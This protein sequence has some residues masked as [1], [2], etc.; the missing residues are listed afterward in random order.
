VDRTERFDTDIDAEGWEEWERLLR[1]HLPP[2]ISL[3]NPDQVDAAVDAIYAA[4]NEACKATM[5]TVGSAPG[6]NSRWWN[7]ECKAAARA[8]RGG[9]W[10]DEEQ[11]AANKHLKTV[12]RN[13]KRRWA[14]EY[15]TT[16]NVWEV[17]AWRHGR[18][19]SHIP[20][21]LNQ[22]NS[23][24]FEHEEMASLLSAR[25][26]AEE[27]VPIPHRFHDDLE[28]RPARAFVPFD[29]EEVEVLLRM[30]ANKLAPGTSGIGWSLLKKGWGAVK[31]HLLII[32][33]ACFYLGHH[34][35]RWR[36]AKVV[37]IPKL[38]KPDYSLPKAH[39]PISLLETM[40]K[41]LEKA[42]AKRM[43]YDI[44]K[45]ELV[46][47]NQFGGRAHSSCL[48][49]GLALL[50]DVQEAHRRGL[51]CGILLFNVRG[52]F[53]NVNHGR[54]TAI[55]ENL[56]YPP[57]LVQWSEAFLKDRKVCL[58]FNN[59]I[60]DERGQ[61]IGVPQGSPLSPVFS[62][63]YTSSLLAMMKGWNNSSL[64]M[65]VDDGI[66]FAC[67]E[68]W[69]DV[70]RLLT[71]RYTVC[72]EWLRRSGLAIKPDKTELLFFQKPYER[73]ATQAPTRLILPDPAIQ[74]YYVVLP[75][76]GRLAVVSDVDDGGFALN[77][78]K[79]LR[80]SAVL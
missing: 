77:V 67:A 8:M 10:T 44:V 42:V 73:N 41:L 40:S 59:V 56:G 35:A 66:L 18:R 20:A 2:L 47:A 63:T 53:D 1:F 69:R 14:D 33:N 9:F 22:S 70:S 31:D 64:G 7:D 37:V 49:A 79:E 45:Y 39:R 46:Q 60:S 23:L 50:H 5:K 29:E 48:D 36:E 54:M 51:K 32:Y 72:E 24:V 74:S 13:A 12:I 68:D 58:S 62:I 25:F 19:S 30:M 71:A 6:F 27:A 4:F 28:P 3:H 55:L 26:F 61:P 21:L 15:I 11:R 43:Q 80:G 76:Y 75:C 16:A 38:D 78:D 65:Y 34:P 57:E 17:A 52:F